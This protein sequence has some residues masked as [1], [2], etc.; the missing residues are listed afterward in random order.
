EVLPRSFRREPGVH[1]AGRAR[2]RDD[3]PVPRTHPGKHLQ[4]VGQPRSDGRAIYPDR[5]PRSEVLSWP[6]SDRRRHRR[7]LLFRGFEDG[8]VFVDARTRIR[9]GPLRAVFDDPG[10][11]QKFFS[12]AIAEQNFALT[13]ARTSANSILEFHTPTPGRSSDFESL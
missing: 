8:D 1:G 3:A 6:L 13:V 10:A 12:R 11:G 9:A 2:R 4:T 7:R 5:T